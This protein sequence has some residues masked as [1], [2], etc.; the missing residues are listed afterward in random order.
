[1]DLHTMSRPDNPTPNPYVRTFL[2]AICI[3]AA[4]TMLGLT[5][6]AFRPQGL[7]LI[8]TGETA[9]PVVES[10][11]NGG[12]RPIELGAALEKLNRAEAVFI[13]ARSEADFNAG[14]IKTARNLPEKNLG[15]WMPDFFSNTPPEAVLIV[16]CSGPRCH[17]AEQLATKLY[18]F[19]YPNAYH[20]TAGWDGWLTAGY[21]KE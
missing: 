20:M 16:Y 11:D 3:A 13:D 5:V 15:L 21:P 6:N 17:L 18:E 10:G 1:M 9:A 4:A 19:G 2:Q 7:D 8:R 14:H 12:A